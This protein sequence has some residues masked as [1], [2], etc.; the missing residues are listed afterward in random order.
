MTRCAIK[1]VV[2]SRMC[3]RWIEVSS[4]DFED[5]A[6]A[7]VVDDDDDSTKMTKIIKKAKKIPRNV[8]T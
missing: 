7:V 8:Y 1:C 4:R 3:V 6:M 5:V 2:C